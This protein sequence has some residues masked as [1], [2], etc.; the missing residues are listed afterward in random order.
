MFKPKKKQPE[1]YTQEVEETEEEVDVS[2]EGESQEEQEKP[3]P[4]QIK[5]VRPQQSG[6]LTRQEIM[7]IIEGNLSRAANLLQYLR[8]M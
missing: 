5:P 4:Q 3:T 7:D 2:E 6:Q 8:N 1:K